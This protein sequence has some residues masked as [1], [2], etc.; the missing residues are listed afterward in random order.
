[1]GVREGVPAR[2]GR[3]AL[4]K[5]ELNGH[6]LLKQETILFETMKEKR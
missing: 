2:A 1:M 3:S 6:N 5:L 4:R